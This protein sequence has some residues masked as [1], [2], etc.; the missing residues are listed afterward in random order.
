V[1]ETTPSAAAGRR[2]LAWFAAGAV[3]WPFRGRPEPY[4]IWVLEVM[5]QQTQLARA[6]AYL[7]KWL[8]SFPDL[9]SL[10]AADESAVLRAWQGLGYYSRARAL[11]RAARLLVA[12]RGGRFPQC[13]A[14]WMS[15]PGVGPYTAAAIASIVYGEA[16]AVVDAN[17]RRVAARLLAFRG[18]CGA[19]AF[20][21][22]AA[23]LVEGFF[24][25]GPPGPVNEALMELGER[26]CRARQ[27]LCAECPLAPD[28]AAYQSGE[29]AAFP[30]QTRPPR[31]A[32]HLV[33]AVCLVE[34]RE[35]RFLIVRGVSGALWPGLWQLPRV[36]LEADGDP[37]L[38]TPALLA[39]AFGIRASVAAVLV[40]PVRHGYTRYRLRFV[41]VRCRLQE[42]AGL[43]VE[44]AWIRPGEAGEYPFP[45]GMRKVLARFFPEDQEPVA[46]HAMPGE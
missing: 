37:A 45:S 24:S 8:V 29:P 9:A 28:C 27:P 25:A 35:G 7:E 15:L 32:L 33:Q 5:A 30:V 31:V 1:R 10:A 22:A 44:H 34:D 3:P 43:A 17:V 20:A 6:A 19:P 2:L 21:A 16:V 18:E 26:V 12:E 13:A 40:P 36:T 39:A 38:R 4:R 23:R 46:R 14:D 42:A 11:H 41:P